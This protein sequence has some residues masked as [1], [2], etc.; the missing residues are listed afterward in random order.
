MNINRLQKQID[1]ARLPHHMAFIIDGNGR[2][3]KKRGLPRTIGHKAGVET[4]KNTVEYCLEIGIKVASFYTFST[5]NWNRPKAEIDEIFNLLR[6]YINK[7]TDEYKAK[8]VKLITSGDLTK[9]PSD[10]Q[11]AL[12]KAKEQTKNNSKLIV[13]IAIN[14]GGRDEIIKAVNNLIK[15]GVKSVTKETFA[16]ELYTANLPEL[17]IIVRTSGER[18]LSNF[19]LYQ[20]A[21]SELYFPKIYWPAFNKKEFYK[22]LIEYQ[23]RNRRFG[24]I[25]K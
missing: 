19:M 6:D 11:K 15:K 10:I 9:L 14:Y 12:K 8:G 20:S 18:R 7:N 2:W 3:A 23:K 13:N 4:V 24:A 5:E 16:K 25:K 17:D 22:A 1:M 21:Y